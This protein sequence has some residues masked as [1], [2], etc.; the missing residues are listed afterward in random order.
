MKPIYWDSLHDISKAHR[1]TWFYQNSMHPVETELANRLEE[2]YLYFQPWTETWQDELNSCVR[3]GAEAEMK[4]VHPLS[5][6][7]DW[8]RT[9]SRP[10][11]KDNNTMPIADDSNSIPYENRAAAAEGIGV[12]AKVL[13][14]S[15]AI[16]V[17][18]EVAQIIRPSLLPSAAK[19][20]APL[21]AIRKGRQ[22]GIPVV[23]GFSWKDWHRLYPPI[24]SPV[25]MRHYL[26]YTQSRVPAPGEEI[27][28]ACAIEESRP[29]PTDLVLVI[30]GIGQ[31]LSERIDSFRFTHAINTLR[32]N[33]NV[34]LN[35]EPVLSHVRE[36]H[37]G[38]M[39]LPVNWRA[40]LSL[41]EQD[42]DGM[43][44]GGGG[45][46]DDDDDSTHFS[47]KDVTPHSIPIVR[48]LISDVMLDIPYY[49]SR[50]KA[51]M[52]QA[53]AKEANRVY[54]L[55]CENNPGFREHGSVHLIAHS[56]G[57]VMAIDI[58]SNQPTRVSPQIGGSRADM[59]DFDTKDL[60]LCGSPAG[61]FLL[62]NKGLIPPWRAGSSDTFLD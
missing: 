38:I 45:D 14:N 42:L 43:S 49:L 27:C 2:G 26:R 16:Y 33:V 39:V 61:F 58:L 28:Y 48:A 13:A 4:I 3:N 44:N 62:L 22:V 34:E 37:G 56:L 17:D 10:G 54:G 25:D 41:D 19:G 51:K 47:L 7:G 23:R 50:H 12:S 1:S 60:F 20:R 30:H 24:P 11:S 59:F 29:R 5:R 52:V 31:K 9:S 40:T 6:N 36:D 18:A 8:S 35:N 32:R 55:W 21:A 53:V 15:S 57:S 46:D